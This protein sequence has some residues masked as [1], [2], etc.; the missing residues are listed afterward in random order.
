M[1]NPSLIS[2]IFLIFVLIDSYVYIPMIKDLIK[3]SEETSKNINLQTWT[4]WTLSG[5]VYLG[6][7]VIE[8]KHPLVIFSAFAHLIGCGIVV[9]L[10][11][12]YRRRY[13]QSIFSKN[14]IN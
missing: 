6:F 5:S 8:I 14:K 1:E 13:N 2:I 7:Y 12:F 11:I 9:G 10:V 3:H 4:W